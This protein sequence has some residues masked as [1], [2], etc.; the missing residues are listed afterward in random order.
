[1]P[2]K[3]AQHIA[4]MIN[5][6]ALDRPTVEVIEQRLIAKLFAAA[7]VPIE[8]TTYTPEQVV[9][10]ILEAGKRA[11]RKALNDATIRFI[12]TRGDVG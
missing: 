12:Q 9:A 4:D 1:M 8:E 2:E 6:G 10:N 5:A 7:G 3:N 11:E